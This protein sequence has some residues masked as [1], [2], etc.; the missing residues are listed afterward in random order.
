MHA[1]GETMSRKIVLIFTAAAVAMMAGCEGESAGEFTRE[2]TGGLIGGVAGAG[3]GGVVGH[4]VGHNTTGTLIGAGVGAGLGYILGNELDK[5]RAQDYDPTQRTELTGTN[6]HVRQ[7]NV[8]NAPPYK[9][10]YLSFEPNSQLVTTTVLPN[11]QVVTATETYRTTDHTLIINRAGQ[12]NQPGYI[13]NAN[14]S[15][16]GDTMNVT[17][18]DFTATLQQVPQ[19]AVNR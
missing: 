12:G 11:G 16:A 18:P 6:W 1:K 5:R 2:H 15:R 14:Y 9:D 3:L 19:V 13:V 10:M 4:A 8:P 7:L 17:S